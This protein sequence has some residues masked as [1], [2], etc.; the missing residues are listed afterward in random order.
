MKLEKRWV[1]APKKSDDIVEQVLINRGIAKSDW[2]KFLDPHYED[3]SD[4][5]KMLGM[6]EGIKRVLK[7]IKNSEVI[8]VFGDYDADGIPATAVLYEGISQC[9]GKAAVYIPARERGYGFSLEG[10]DYLKGLGVSLIITVDLGMTAKDEVAYAAKQGIDVIVIDHHT[11]QLDKLPERAVAIVNPK[12]ANDKS[13]FKDYAACGLAYKFVMA[14]AQKTGK[15]SATELKWMLDLP[16]ISTVGDMVPL[17]GENRVITK[18]GLIVLQ[19]TRRI[20]LQ[21]LY[22]KAAIEPSNIAA[23]TLSFAIAPRLNSPGRMEKPGLPLS[24]VSSAFTLLTTKDEAEAERL[25][26]EIDTVN[27]ERQAVLDKVITEARAQIEKDKLHEK[28]VILVVGDEWPAGVVGL[29]A[30]RIM[31]EYCRPTIVLRKEQ[32]IVKGSARSLEAFN[33]ME[34]FDTVKKHL[35]KHGGHPRAAGLSMEYKHLE[36]VYD[37]L[38]AAADAKLTPEDLIPKIKVDAQVPLKEITVSLYNQL[39]KLEPHGMGNPKPVLLINNLFIQNARTVGNEDKHLKI[40]FKQAERSIG[41]IGFDLGDLNSNLNTGDI[42]DVV[43]YLD[44][45][46]WNGA[47]KLNLKVLDLKIVV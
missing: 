9:G 6:Q 20:G 16:A 15:I 23:S 33:I 38:Q 25:A 47:K 39:K 12:Q 18:Y 4:P 37:K 29:V 2:K 34:A 28:K 8:G 44:Q 26:L 42:V 36:M 17:V 43:G 14:L 5:F 13:P 11:V 41:G 27:R 10:I 24:H 1:V 22:K 7:A 19:K 21:K 3:L 32:G 45:D 30:G 46:E 40:T 31:D 35:L